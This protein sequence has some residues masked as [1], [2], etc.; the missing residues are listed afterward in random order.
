MPDSELDKISPVDISLSAREPVPEANA[1]APASS[2]LPPLGMSGSQQLIQNQQKNKKILWGIFSLLLILVLGVMFILPKFVSPS[3]SE[4]T[5]VVVRTPASPG[6]NQGREVTPF[7]EAQI[8]KQ[9]ENAQNT[10]ATLLELQESL[11][12]IEVELWAEAEMLIAIKHAESGDLAY[13]QQAFEEAELSYLQGLEA[14]QAIE[15]SIPAMFTAYMEKG[16]AAIIAGDSTQA[17]QAFTIA[18]AI[19][20]ES[21]EAESSHSRALV[22]GEV[23]ALFE[24]GLALHE[25]NLLEEARQLYQQAMTI[26]AEHIA[27]REALS[28]LANDIIERDFSSFMSKGYASIQAD[29]PELA[30][31]AFRQA[32]ALK[33]DSN[34][35][36]TA[37]EQAGDQ[38][39]FEAITIHL[40]AAQGYANA[41]R[42]QEALSEYEQAISVDPNVVSAIDGRNYS[43]SRNNLDIF[44]NNT[45]ASPLRLADNSVYEQALQVLSDARNLPDRGPR[46]NEQLQKVSV[47]L[48]KV[49][50]VVSVSFVSNGLTKVSIAR[51]SELGLFTTETFSLTPGTYTAIGIRDGFRDVREEFIVPID[52]QV[53]LITVQCD[54]AI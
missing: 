25:D 38:I 28:R 43:N 13:S 53:P 47:L 14:L 23:V 42:W 36:I 1:T 6:G 35:A 45:I 24:E 2:N 46:L 19:S 51:I 15:A 34:Q 52:G 50:Q 37:L 5:V 39:T 18:M 16:H 44:L 4:P 20:P 8:L 54:E 29:A 27:S 26:D 9:R 49:T 3:E 40:D 31:V 11:E 12:E 33:P 22:L 32:L 17:Q 30:E 48:D 41:E 10:L 21:T 7:Q